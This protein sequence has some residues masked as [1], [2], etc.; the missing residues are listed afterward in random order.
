MTVL[1]KF[2]EADE[3]IWVL[4]VFVY[5]G[6]DDSD[7]LHDK[8]LQHTGPLPPSHDRIWSRPLAQD[9]LRGHGL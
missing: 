9:L 7:V 2:V 8:R 5:V 3:L 6:I 4:V 1:S